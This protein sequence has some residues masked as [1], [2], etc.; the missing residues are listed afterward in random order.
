MTLEHGNGHSGSIKCGESLK[1]L[2][3]FRLVTQEL[4]GRHVVFAAV[5]EHKKSRAVLY[6]LAAWRCGVNQA[7]LFFLKTFLKSVFL[8]CCQY[9]C[10]LGG[11]L[12][13]RWDSSAVLEEA[14]GIVVSG[15]RF[16]CK[17]SVLMIY[18]TKLS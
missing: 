12:S 5:K 4:T 7:G 14:D 8:F 15:D 16:S 3:H 11:A 1:R 10:C 17:S 18:V 2:S 13:R 9:R 6:R